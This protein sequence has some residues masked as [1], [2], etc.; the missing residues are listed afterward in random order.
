MEI[1]EIYEKWFH[2]RNPQQEY[3]GRIEFTALDNIIS[4]RRLLS[5][6]RED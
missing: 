3:C 6:R 5:S 2:E 4:I 1:M